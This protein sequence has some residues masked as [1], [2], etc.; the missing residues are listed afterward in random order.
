M[1]KYSEKICTVLF[2]STLHPTISLLENERDIMPTCKCKNPVGVALFCASSRGHVRCHERQ[3]PN[4]P[5]Y[6]AV[7]V[8]LQQVPV[9]TLFPSSVLGNVLG[10]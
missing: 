6:Q 2:G 8:G 5:K 9:A 4:P 3:L 1:V 10:G 7:N